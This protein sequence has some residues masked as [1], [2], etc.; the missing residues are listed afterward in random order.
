MFSRQHLT[1]SNALV[2][3]FDQRH[4]A[5]LNRCYNLLSG[6]FHDAKLGGQSALRVEVVAHLVHVGHVGTNA[7]RLDSVGLAML[8]EENDH[9]WNGRSNSA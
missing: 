1:A 4:L 3:A 2:S 7:D 8:F 9:L 6:A 5:R